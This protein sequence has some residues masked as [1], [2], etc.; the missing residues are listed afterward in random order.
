VDADSVQIQSPRLFLET[1]PS[2]RASKGF[3]NQPD[4]GGTHDG[5]LRLKNAYDRAMAAFRHAAT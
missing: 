4:Q 2:A 1:S 3:L 5:I